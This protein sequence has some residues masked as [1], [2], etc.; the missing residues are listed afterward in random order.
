MAVSEAEAS[1]VELMEIVELGVPLGGS[2]SI[3]SILADQL[4]GA[5][6]PV[7]VMAEGPKGVPTVAFPKLAPVGGSEITGGFL[8]TFSVKFFVELWGLV[9][10]PVTVTA[11][12]KFPAD[13][14]FPDSTPVVWFM[15]MVGF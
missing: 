2:G 15:L 1:L 10:L 8:M 7:A 12:V 3:L 9:L 11:I 13:E 5:T 4:Y 6:P 14:K